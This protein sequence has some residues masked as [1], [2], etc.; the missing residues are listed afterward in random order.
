MPNGWGSGVVKTFGRTGSP[1]FHDGEPMTRGRR[2][3]RAGA[4]ETVEA[5]GVRPRGGGET[6]G[7]AGTTLGPLGSSE[8]CGVAVTRVSAT[9]RGS[10]LASSKT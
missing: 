2:P 3:S 7:R 6:L 1:A 8:G 5:L 9:P 10:I 4:G